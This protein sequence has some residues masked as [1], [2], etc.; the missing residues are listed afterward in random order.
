MIVSLMI[1]TVARWRLAVLML[2]REKIIEWIDHDNDPCAGSQH[3]DE[4]RNQQ[5][6]K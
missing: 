5:Q 3:R 2:G 1:M 6:R 4:R